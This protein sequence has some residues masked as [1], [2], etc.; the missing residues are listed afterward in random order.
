MKIELLSDI[1][2]EF[3][4]DKGKSFLDSLDPSDVDVLVLAGDIALAPDI[5]R[6][7]G[8][9]CEKYPK[10][11]YVHGNHEYYKHGV[12]VNVQ[13][14][15]ALTENDNLIWLNNKVVEIDGVRFIGGTM[16][17]K[18]DPLSA[19]YRSYM[20][21]F[22]VIPDFTDWVFEENAKTIKL[23]DE[24]MQYGDVVVT[25][26]L[27]TNQ[28][29]APFFKGDPLNPFFL[30]DQEAF[31]RYVKP[32]LWLHGHTHASMDYEIGS[33]RVVC[34][35]FGYLHDPNREYKRTILEVEPQ[36]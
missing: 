23:F 21:D 3:H 27:P 18:D 6:L 22:S 24:K 13:T 36:G 2:F 9:F 31:I 29:I 19:K 28:S 32:A 11:V 1:H 15:Q 30:C 16:W 7:L 35:P 12:M 20:S 25:H 17:F 8:L 5:A 34:N 14:E 26:H 10:V 4:R 33:T